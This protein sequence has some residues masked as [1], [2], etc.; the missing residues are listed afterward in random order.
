MRPPLS[1]KKVKCGWCKKTVPNN[2]IGIKCNSCEHFF[3]SKSKC[4]GIS[5]KKYSELSNWFC[6]GCAI[7]TL[8][9]SHIDNT[10]LGL[11]LQGK[12]IPSR[13][14]LT[15]FPSFTIRSLLDKIP[16]NITIQ[17]DEFLSDS[18]ESKYYT[19]N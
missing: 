6:D 9:F 10:R 18:T 4:S 8:P 5:L 17:T 13:D 7:S 3:H 2:N 14:N 11:T 1:P 16:G 19:P 12:E 15:I